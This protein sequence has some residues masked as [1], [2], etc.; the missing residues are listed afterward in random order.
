MSHPEET[1]ARRY[2]HWTGA[3]NNISNAMKYAQDASR[4]AFEANTGPAHEAAMNAALDAIRV[5]LLASL[6]FEADRLL[7][8]ARRH[9]HEMEQAD[10]RSLRQQEAV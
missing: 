5:G 6:P 2:A 1:A 3:T 8:M 10:R 4:C 9:A 7:S